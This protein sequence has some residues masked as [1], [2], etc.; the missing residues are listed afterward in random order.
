MNIREYITTIN[1][2][3]QSGIAREHTYRTDLEN[4]IREI[5]PEVEITNEPA[6]YISTKHNILIIFR[7]LRGSFTL[8]DTNRHK[9]G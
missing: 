6:E 1:K 9:N 8:A 3:F 4:L 5:V 7:L 2:R